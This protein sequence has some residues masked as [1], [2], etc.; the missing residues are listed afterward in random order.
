MLVTL[1]VTMHAVVF[2]RKDLWSP[3]FPEGFAFAKPAGN[4]S[5]LSFASQNQV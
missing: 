2:K 3:W 1:R 4:H 5:F